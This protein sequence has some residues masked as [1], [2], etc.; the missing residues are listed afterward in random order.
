ME[1]CNTSKK[2]KGLSYELEFEECGKDDGVSGVEFFLSMN[3][4]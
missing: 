3:M 4:G 2:V 1:K